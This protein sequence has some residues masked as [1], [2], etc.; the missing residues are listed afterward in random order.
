MPHFGH[1]LSSMIAARVTGHVRT[2]YEAVVPRIVVAE[3]ET[4]VLDSILYGLQ[5]E[6]FAASGFTDGDSALE[7]VEAGGYDVVVLDILMPGLSGLD[8]CRRVRERSFVPIILLTAK[9]REI[10][11]VLG[12]ELGADDYMVKPFSLAELASRIRSLLRR[13][14]LDRAVGAE[15]ARSIGGLRVDIGRHSVAVDGTEA[16]LTHSEFK[17]VALLASRPGRVFS[18]RQLMEHVW[19]GDYDGDERACDVHVSNLRRKLELDHA[20][21]RRIVTVAGIGYRLEAA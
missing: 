1:S 11:R 6:G 19:N 20:R 2:E 17:L 5:S 10:D 16:R 15:P 8:V 3:D 18:R 4:D 21:P 9:D 12:L 14:E 13:I 7:A